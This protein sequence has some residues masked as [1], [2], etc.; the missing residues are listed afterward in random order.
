[1]VS[2]SYS[3]LGSARSIDYILSDKELGPSEELGRQGIVGANGKEILSE[4]RF[5]QRTNKRCFNNTISLIISPAP[6]DAVKLNNKQ[7]KKILESQLSHLGLS[8]HQY[9]STVHRSTG[10]P[11][12][13]AII[14]RIHPISGR[15]INDSYLSKRAQSG[16]EQIAIAMGLQTARQIQNETKARTRKL[17][18]KVLSRL[19]RGDVKNWSQFLRAMEGIGLKIEIV[20]SKIENKVNGYKINEYKASEI[21]RSLTLT[22]IEETLQKFSNNQRVIR[23]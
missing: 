7:L 9:I 3:R 10:K 18:E 5:I 15:A 2:K 1:M 17:K 16:A 22:R 8:E 21:D 11:H 12:I 13:H 19:K 20:K 6:D 14:N 4:F 23:R